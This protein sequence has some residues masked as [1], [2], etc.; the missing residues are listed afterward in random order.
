M[1]KLQKDQIKEYLMQVTALLESMSSSLQA[2][3]ENVWKYAGYREYIRKYNQLLNAISKVIKVEC[4]VD[5]Y[6]ESK[7]KGIANTLAIQQKELFESVKAN[8]SILK[9]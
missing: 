8:I 5:A 3:P 2:D 9:A 4:V 1:D 7:I 6:D